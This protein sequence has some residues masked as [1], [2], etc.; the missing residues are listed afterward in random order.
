MNLFIIVSAYLWQ[1]AAKMSLRLVGWSLVA[2]LPATQKYLLIGAPHTSSWDFPIALLMLAGMGLKLYWVGKDSLFKGIKGTVMRKLGGI[3]VERG[4]RKNFVGQI[5]DLYD[6]RDKMVLTIAPEGTRKY[7]D[8]WKTGFYNIALN[9]KIP[10]ALGFVDYANKTCGVGGFFT[11]TGDREAD[12]KT[13]RKFYADKSGKFPQ[14]TNKIR[15]L[16]RKKV[17]PTRDD[18]IE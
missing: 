12:L 5:V 6:S 18:N 8:H 4:A 11:P 10:I 7:L 17:V 9:A 15:F 13:L 2:D 3:P 14:Q 1:R 16:V